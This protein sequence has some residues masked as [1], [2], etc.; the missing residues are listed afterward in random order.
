M[1]FPVK[2]SKV[3]VDKKVTNI[4]METD[5]P[6]TERYGIDRE[7]IGADTDH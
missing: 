7:A 2:Y 4:I 6:I 5:E 3:I 1:V